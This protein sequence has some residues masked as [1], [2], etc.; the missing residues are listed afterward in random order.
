LAPF[1]YTDDIETKVTIKTDD[2]D[3]DDYALIKSYQDKLSHSNQEN[4][5]L[6]QEKNEIGEEKLKEEQKYKKIIK[7]LR[8]EVSTENNLNSELT[9]KLD[10]EFLKVAVLEENLNIIKECMC[11]V[12]PGLLNKNCKEEI[13]S[14]DEEPRPS[15]SKDA[16]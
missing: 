9:R 7:R 8:T 15:T 6:I 11:K 14:S 16:S 2:D 3:D 1:H 4:L 13:L 10:E 5:R 12:F